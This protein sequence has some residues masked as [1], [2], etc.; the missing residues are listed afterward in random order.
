M[1]EFG[2]NDVV[3]SAAVYGADKIKESVDFPELS[4]KVTGC[5]NA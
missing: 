1:V 4:A 5:V 2:R 3:L